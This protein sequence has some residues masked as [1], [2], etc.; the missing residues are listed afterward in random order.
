MAHVFISYHVASDRQLAR[1]FYG[2]LSEIG[3]L[4]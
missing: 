1:L 2:T 4:N 3:A